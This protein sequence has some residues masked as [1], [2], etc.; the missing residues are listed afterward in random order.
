MYSS[1]FDTWS[2]LQAL[3]RDTFNWWF[4]PIQCIHTGVPTFLNL[5]S[6]PPPFYPTVPAFLLHVVWAFTFFRSSQPFSNIVLSSL[7]ALP[8]CQM[9]LPLLTQYSRIR[10]HTYVPSYY[11]NTLATRAAPVAYTLSPSTAGSARL[12]LV[13]L[14]GD[15]TFLSGLVSRRRIGGDHETSKHCLAKCMP[16]LRSVHHL[17]ARRGLLSSNKAGGRRWLLN[18]AS[19]GT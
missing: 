11:K 8:R 1:L 14:Y 10:S 4:Q 12:S 18:P 15:S 13:W 2:V 6:I 19:Q 3:L 16:L 7:G 5:V 17:Q 9:I